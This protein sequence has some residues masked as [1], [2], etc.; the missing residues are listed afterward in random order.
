YVMAQC[1]EFEEVGRQ[2]KD[3]DAISDLA[4]FGK[5]VKESSYLPFTSSADALENASNLAEGKISSRLRHF[6]EESLPASKKSFVLG[7]QD[8]SLASSITAEL[9]YA[10]D[11]SERV[12]ELGRGIRTHAEKL[13][14]GYLKKGDIQRGQLGLGH[15]YS[16]SKV[17]FSA[18]RSDTMAMQ[19]INLLDM[20]D[21]D[22]N[23]FTMR[24]REWYS[25]HFPELAKIIGDNAQYSQLVPVIR[26]KNSLSES[27]LDSLTQVTGDEKKSQEIIEAA[28][29]SMGSAIS[30]LDM[31]DITQFANR[32]VELIKFRK[33]L[34]D[35]LVNKME[36]V[37]PNL[38]A[39]L[40]EVVSA[41]LISHAGGLRNL[42]KYPASTLQILGAEKALFRALKTKSA[43][44]KFG[45]FY[46]STFIGSAGFK[47]K[48]KI[49]RFLANKCS[50]ASRIDCFSDLPTSKF[51]EA[52]S[53]LKNYEV[54]RQV[55]SEIQQETLQKT[56]EESDQMAIDV[57]EPV[58]EGTEGER[59]KE[60][61]KDKTKK[62]K[63][64]SSVVESSK[65]KMKIDKEPVEETVKE[66][67]KKNAKKELHD[68][69]SAE[70]KD[71]VKK[72]KGNKEIK[73]EGKPKD[74]ESKAKNK[75]TK[76]EGKSKDK[77]LRRKIKTEG[78]S[79]D[80]K[81]KT[82]GKVKDKREQD[83]R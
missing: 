65:K 57:V 79:K 34:H 59:V 38:A 12:L 51:G 56:A 43:T 69:K 48:G 10:C 67:S 50:I 1:L 20:L 52:S 30:E 6:L 46:H 26:D 61:T 53:P 11:T 31:I 29:T 62:R 63:P 80:E 73:T 23:T 42:S 33:K 71:S 9:E 64:K 83:E 22:I 27:S 18:E 19:A 8:K 15:N 77:G 3:A 66:S 5:I 82:E 2:L 58:K 13:L 75:E 37:A 7:V 21:K 49:S 4:K 41:R 60:G 35:Y 28:H 78:K 55:I 72:D 25:W 32:V 40:G 36:N 39:L 16:K 47:S 74:K 17:K 44:P 14:S 70:Q 24:V 68:N 76:T 54:M 81:S 45:L